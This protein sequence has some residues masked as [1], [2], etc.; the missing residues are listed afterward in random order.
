M[1][2]K[3]LLHGFKIGH[4]T[5]KK[6]Q[7]G[8]TVL[9][10]PNGT[11]ASGEIRG[12]APGSRETALLSPEKQVQEINAIFLTGGS[13]FGLGAANGVQKYLHEKNIGYK[14]P[15]N[16]IPIVPAAVIYDYNI[17]SNKIFPTEKNAYEAC[18]TASNNFEVGQVGA[19]TG[20]TV[21]K[22]NGIE[23]AM[24]GGFG[25][26]RIIFK[27]LIVEVYAVVNSVGDI[28]A[29]D[30]KI[31]AGTIKNKKFLGSLGRWENFHTERA[32]LRNSNTTLVVVT[33]NAKL[34]KVDAF[35]VSQRVH[36]GMSRAIKPSHTTFDGDASFTLCT[37]EI[38]VAVDLVAEISAEATSMAIR[39]SVK[40]STPIKK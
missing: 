18:K 37:G 27:N 5:N 31:I 35:R 32:L 22:W 9:L 6:A 23:T 40:N 8:C 24:H 19:A 14:T 17:G 39:N 15:W 28:I 29:D 12:S 7:T 2:E 38:L 10:A 34:N 26:S 16:I 1:R 13:A 36:D 11:I 30:G 25:F 4:Y 33:T 20:A 3:N 21:G